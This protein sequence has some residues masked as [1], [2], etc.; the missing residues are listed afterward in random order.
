M[1]DIVTNGKVVSLAYT[2]RLTNGDVIDQSSADDPLE[3][4]HGADNIVP[5]L[6]RELEGLAVGAAKEIVVAPVD[7]YGEYDAEN[8]EKVGKDELPPDFPLQLDMIVAIEDDEGFTEE[9]R[10]IEVSAN[11]V[12]LDFNHPLAGQ[13]LNFSVEVVGIREATAEELEHG[14]PHGVDFFDEDD[15]DD[16]DEFDY[17]DEDDEDDEEE[18]PRKR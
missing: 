11:T 16:D 5:G 3:Y 18:A 12:T 8:V 4:L 14:H 2:L 7:G 17:D 1:A 10:V 13:T 6:E 15:F 9:A